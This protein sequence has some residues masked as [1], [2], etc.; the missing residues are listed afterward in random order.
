M[1]PGR[2]A[3]GRHG[4]LRPREGLHDHQA[5]RLRRVGAHA[6]R[7][8]P[9]HQGDR[10][11]Q[12]LL[13]AVRA[14]EPAGAREGARGGLLARV[15]V[16]DDRRRGRARGAARDPAD[17]RGDHLLDLREV[18][19]VLAGPA[20]PHQP[21]GERGPL[22]EGHPPLPAHDR[23]PLAGGPHP[24]RHRRG[25]SGGDAQDARRLPG[26]L[27]GDAGHAGALR[28]ED[29]EREVRRCAQ[30]LRDRGADGRRP[31]AAGRDEP[32]PRPALLRGL[33][34]RVPGQEPGAGQAVVHLVGD[35]D[36]DDR[37]AHHDPRRRLG[38]RPAA[39][40]GARTRS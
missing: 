27:R 21:V 26:L 28:P 4:R 30:D 7:H 16:G 25:G 35:L 33:R 1:V 14:E 2:G 6:A 10:P 8:G 37:R 38:A 24:P 9:A 32:Q 17:V 40:G 18:G 13:P 12:R 5:L 3:Q 34:H 29:R 19:A 23:V 15:R 11:R 36:P 22:G 31:G 39:E 20:R